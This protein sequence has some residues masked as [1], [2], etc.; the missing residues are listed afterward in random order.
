MIPINQISTVLVT[1]AKDLANELM[2]LVTD[3]PQRL[4]KAIEKIPNM[5]NT[6]RD[7]FCPAYLKYC[8]GL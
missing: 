1:S 7:Q 6:I 3:T 2:Y 4:N 5:I 8:Y